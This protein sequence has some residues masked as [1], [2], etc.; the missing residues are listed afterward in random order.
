MTEDYSN[1]LIQLAGAIKAVE[2][3]T[4]GDWQSAESDIGTKFPDDFKRLVSALGSGIFGDALYL[5]NPCASLQYHSLSKT[6]LVEY[7]EILA[8][9]AQEANIS[10]YPAVGGLIS[11]GG[12]ERQLFFWKPD[13]KG[14]VWL[15][16]DFDQTVNIDMSIT[17]FI[18]DLYLGLIKEAWAG[19]LRNY[20]WFGQGR[21]FFKPLKRTELLS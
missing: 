6:A 1:K 14:L 7:G 16:V 18:H 19:E 9:A 5:R 20:I 13:D 21:E 15:D 4:S 12:M 10:L 17:Q 3:P 11:L 8:Y 2:Q